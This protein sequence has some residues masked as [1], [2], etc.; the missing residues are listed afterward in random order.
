MGQEGP[1]VE[2]HEADKTG[3]NMKESLKSCSCVESRA[4][5]LCGSQVVAHLYALVKSF[6]KTHQTFHFFL[7]CDVQI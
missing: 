1:K 7:L 4:H 6:G 5:V 3:K 2:L